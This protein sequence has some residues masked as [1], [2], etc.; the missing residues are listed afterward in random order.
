MVITLPIRKLFKLLLLCVWFQT[1]KESKCE[2]L[3]L[4]LKGVV[5][6][7]PCFLWNY[8]PAWNFSSCLSPPGLIDSSV[9]RDLHLFSCRVEQRCTIS[10]ETH[11]HLLQWCFASSCPKL[12]LLSTV[13]CWTCSLRLQSTLCSHLDCTDSM[14]RMHSAQ[15]VS[16]CA[17]WVEK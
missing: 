7:C 1:V 8:Y 11:T 10:L 6:K 5:E 14:Q 9:W 15:F 17:I 13:L 2:N 16:D 3:W 12:G 4:C